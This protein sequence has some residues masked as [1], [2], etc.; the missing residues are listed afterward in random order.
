MPS[1]YGKYIEALEELGFVDSAESADSKVKAV[2]GILAS[3]LEAPY[4]RRFT[5]HLPDPLTHEK[6]VG[7]QATVTGITVEQFV[8]DVADQF[9]LSTDESQLLINSVIGLAKE[10]LDEETLEEIEDHLPTEWARMVRE[11]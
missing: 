10:D 1:D 8:R 4:S 7:H 2:L 9:R 11:A 3:R 5:E 6:L